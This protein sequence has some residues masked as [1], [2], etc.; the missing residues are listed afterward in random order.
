MLNV[1]L[2]NNDIVIEW[3]WMPPDRHKIWHTDREYE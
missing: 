1:A 3:H 2:V